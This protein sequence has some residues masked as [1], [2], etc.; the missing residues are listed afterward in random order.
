M[1]PYITPDTLRGGHPIRH[2]ADRLAD[3]LSNL[4]RRQR[5]NRLHDLDDHM[6]DDLGVTRGEVEIASALPLSA[7]AATELRRISLDRRRRKM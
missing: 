3:R 4:R 5:F 6:L 7:D 2:L 1:N